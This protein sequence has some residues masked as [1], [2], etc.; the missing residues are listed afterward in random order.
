MTV[1]FNATEE[2][3]EEM[4]NNVNQM[5]VKILRITK[6]ARLIPNAE[7]L[8]ITATHRRN[9]EIIRLDRYVGELVGVK[10]DDAPTYRKAEAIMNAL[11]KIAR[12]LGLEVRAGMYE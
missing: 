6:R 1:K 11:E 9:D 7:R 12:E 5:P 2:Y 8:F 10:A 3:I 4:S